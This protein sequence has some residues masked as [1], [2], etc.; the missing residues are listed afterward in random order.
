[1]CPSP[2]PQIPVGTQAESRVQV[3][4]GC[5]QGLVCDTFPWVLPGPLGG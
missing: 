2:K 1:M 4:L 3:L 5:H